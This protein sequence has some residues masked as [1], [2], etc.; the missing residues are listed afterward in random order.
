MTK[1]AILDYQAE[2]QSI[3]NMGLLKK[4]RIITGPQSAEI[5]P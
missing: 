2:L 1:S 4:E 3:E 5:Q